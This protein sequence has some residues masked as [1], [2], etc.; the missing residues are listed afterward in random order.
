MQSNLEITTRFNRL[1]SALGL[2]ALL[3]VIVLL[4]GRRI[5][6]ISDE[7][8]IFFTMALLGFLMCTF[9]GMRGI[10]SG[11][12]LSWWS[13]FG[14]AM[15][16]LAGVLIIAMLFGIKLPFISGYRDATLI[17]ACII[18]SNWVVGLIAR[19]TAKVDPN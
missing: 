9:G 6:F 10:Q 18:L 3:L 17:L 8:W 19:H 16:I 13:I 7:R 5:P 12:W 14:I 1:S 4:T 15:G 2:V 11:E